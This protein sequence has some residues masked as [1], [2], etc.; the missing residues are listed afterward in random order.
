MYAFLKKRNRKS[1]IYNISS[2]RNG[3][4]INKI[5][6][7]ITFTLNTLILINIGYNSMIKSLLKNRKLFSLLT[8]EHTTTRVCALHK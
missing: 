6:L 8:C 2:N 1:N 7:K 4:L 3:S 5:Y